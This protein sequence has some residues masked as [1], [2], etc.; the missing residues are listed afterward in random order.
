MR[1]KTNGVWGKFSTPSVWAL[2][3]D[4]TDSRIVV[5]TGHGEPAISLG[6]D[7]NTYI[8]LSGFANRLNVWKKIG[9]VWFQV[10]R[11][12]DAAAWSASEGMPF[13]PP[14]PYP[15]PN[16]QTDT[17]QFAFR[18]A[19]TETV[20]TSSPT[21]ATTVVVADATH[22]YIYL[23]RRLRASVS[24]AWGEWSPWI[25]WDA[26]DVAQ[27]PPT[28][29]YY[30][31]TTT[32]RI[33]CEYNNGGDSRLGW[34]A[35]ADLDFE[36]Q[37][38]WRFGQNHPN[39]AIGN[40]GDRYYHWRT[41]EWYER[42]DGIYIVQGDLTLG[43]RQDAR[44]V[45]V[46]SPLDIRAQ[47]SGTSVAFSWSPNTAILAQ[48]S[49]GRPI[50]LLGYEGAIVQALEPPTTA[51]PLTAAPA[52]PPTPD[53]IGGNFAGIRDVQVTR[54]TVSYLATDLKEGAN[55]IARLRAIY[56]R[57]TT[58]A[59]D[60]SSVVGQP[61]PAARLTQRDFGEGL[62]DV[63]VSIYATYEF[64][65]NVRFVEATIDANNKN[66]AS[67]AGRFTNTT[68]DGTNPIL[69]LRK[70]AND[71][72]DIVG[73]FKR[74]G[75]YNLT[76]E[77]TAMQDIISEADVSITS[78]IRLKD[79]LN[80]ISDPLQKLALLNGY[81]FDK[82]GKR[83]AGLIAQELQ[84]VL[85]EGVKDKNGY[86]LIS[87]VAAIALLVSSVNELQK[88]LEALKKSIKDDSS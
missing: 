60:L 64:T 20:P 13:H 16:D 27:Q 84:K 61:V 58:Q 23:S 71:S 74:D 22:P 66:D 57:G 42:I 35:V 11:N 50:E 79:N 73:E 3:S 32:A 56:E 26:Y 46:P 28:H 75:S 10:S 29:V 36:G 86:L 63:V 81:T 17:E 80:T 85:P 31:D 14:F 48:D 62:V 76:G 39:D 88:Q 55:Y 15:T 78:D 38:T 6:L 40:D 65:T 47:I 51:A 2:F 33:Y 67:V 68:G 30:A 87:P 19:M 8:Q 82:K 77:L 72:E 83:Q 9:G 21:A 43:Y 25:L 24:D 53:T 69:I 7:G 37:N 54:D 18:L 52:V 59:S 70:G 4:G 45:V 44:N 5:L 34:V 41:G 12:P 49:R 1:R